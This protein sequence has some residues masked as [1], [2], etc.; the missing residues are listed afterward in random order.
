[1]ASRRSLRNVLSGKSPSNWLETIAQNDAQNV[2]RCLTSQRAERKA[3]EALAEMDLA[4]GG[5]PER[6]DSQAES[7]SEPLPR[8]A[9]IGITPKQSM[10]WQAEASVPEPVFERHV[11][12]ARSSTR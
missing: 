8:L 3:G 5:R 10:N 6:T 7:V 4:K 12:A 11:S 1:M 2:S 9:D